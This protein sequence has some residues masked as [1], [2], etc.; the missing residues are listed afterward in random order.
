MLIDAIHFVPQS[1]PRVFIVAVEKDVAIPQ[2]LVD[3]Q[4]NWLHNKAAVNL[5]KVLPEWIF[6]TMF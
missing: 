1:R 6:F 3:T 2:E 5:G 4:P